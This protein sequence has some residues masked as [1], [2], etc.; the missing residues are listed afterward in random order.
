MR[1]LTSTIEAALAATRRTPALTCQL[2][3]PI[4][5]YALYQT[6]TVPESHSA[7][8][9]ANDGSLLRA[10]TDQPINAFAASLFVQRITDPATPT[11]WTTWTTL[12]PATLLRDAGCTLSNHNGTLRLFAQSGSSPYPL[13]VWTSTDHGAT[14][15]GPVTIAPVNAAVRGLG[16]AGQNDL[17]FAQDDTGGVSLAL[18]TYNGTSWSAPA[19]WTLGVLPACAGLDAAYD[20]STSSFLLAISDGLQLSAYRYTPATASWAFIGDIAPLDPISATGLSRIHPRLHT[21]DGR[22]SLSYLEVDSGVYTGL[23]TR[24][25]R[26]RQ[27]LDFIHWSDGTLLSQPFAYGPTWLKAP[28]P[29]QG[30]A[31]PAYYLTNNVYTWRAPVYDPGNPALTLDI[32]D[33]LLAIERREALCQP[34]QLT[35]RLSNASGQYNALPM[36]GLNT[37]LTL[38]EGYLD[39]ATSTKSTIPIGTYYIDTITFERAPDQNTLR[40]TARDA[41]KRL[42]RAARLQITYAGQT[43]AWLLTELAARAGLF[44]VTIP[45]TPQFSHTVK[46]Y[47]VPAGH[48]L[49]RALD[50]LCAIYA[51]SYFLDETE[52][53]HFRELDASDP[54][55]WAYQP[56]IETL[57]LGQIEQSANHLIVTGRAPTGTLVFG[58]A[59][60][61]AHLTQTGLERPRYHIDPRLTTSEEAAMKATFLLAEEQRKSARHTITVPAHPGLQLLD[62]LTLTDQPAPTG[63]SQSVSARITA[64]TVTYAPERAIAETT[65]ELEQP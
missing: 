62:V 36:L 26:L 47:T 25:A 39:P 45:A 41:T 42:D 54:A 7:A 6:T 13:L 18:T 16:S 61:F 8:C 64:L 17:F 52:T 20:P 28:N 38:A 3:D 22:F 37:S 43:L 40:L 24:Y 59:Y 55:V 34:G 10:Y 31:G 1:T 23:P 19:T 50:D 58:E 12:A 27:S 2:F 49:R 44:A 4:A 63:T 57:T 15:S 56:E 33:H 65:L 35:L 5:H 9:I 32:S 51:V 53:L 21:F 14:W 48:T 11:Q 29:P 46:S 30:S 60:D